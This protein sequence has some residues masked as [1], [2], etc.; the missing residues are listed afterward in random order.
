MSKVFQLES[1]GLLYGIN[2]MILT[3]T[4]H[5]L[6]LSLMKKSFIS[7]AFCHKPYVLNKSKILLYNGTW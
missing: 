5:K 1:R 6:Q 2:I 7:Q 3:F 4:N